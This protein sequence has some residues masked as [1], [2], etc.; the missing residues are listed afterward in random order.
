MISHYGED[1]PMH[2]KLKII[3]LDEIDNL[4]I[5]IGVRLEEI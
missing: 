1:L 3:R 2:R 4:E 5:K